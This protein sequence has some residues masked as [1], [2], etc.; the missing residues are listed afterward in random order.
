MGD[1]KKRRIASPLAARPVTPDELLL[2][3]AAEHLW[4][5]W[6]SPHPLLGACHYITFALH[7]HLA[8]AHDVIVPV[9]A[10]WVRFDGGAWS[11]HS[12]LETDGRKTDVA[13]HYPNP[14]APSGD[15]LI[16]GQ[17][18][19]R[20]KATA[21][22]S[23]APVMASRPRSRRRRISPPVSD[24]RKSGIWPRAWLTAAT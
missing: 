16:D 8:A 4:R 2:R 20:G 11:K 6:V 23:L 19:A 10:G 1:A 22:Y 21:L 18:K 15:L 5:D 3:R 13:I 12:W 7:H 14:P 17:R 9:R 24:A